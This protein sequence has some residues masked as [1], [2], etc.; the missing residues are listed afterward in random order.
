ME[1]RI[2]KTVLK[3]SKQGFSLLELLIYVAVLSGL[4]VVVG[5]SFIGLS[6][7]R[8]QSEARS[9]VNAAV[10]FASE[11]IKQDLKSATSLVAPVLGT[12]SS[13]LEMVVPGFTIKYDTLNG[14]LRRTEGTGLATTTTV[15]TGS[16]IFVESPTFVRIENHNQP[17]SA[18]TT[19][20]KI[21]AI[22]RYNASS[23]DWMYQSTLQT[24]ISLR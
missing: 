2:K 17:L 24:T 9:E 3:I 1:H 23:T 21:S 5:N 13:T 7:G 14:Q 10:R 8:G 6:K 18:T 19:A 20:V 12:A 4:M 16:G 15:V 11:K 22:F